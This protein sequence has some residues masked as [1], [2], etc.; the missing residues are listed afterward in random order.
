MNYS[1]SV[2]VGCIGMLAVPT[3]FCES[4]SV[5]TIEELRVAIH[6][7]TA[8]VRAIKADLLKVQIEASAGRLRHLEYQWHVA[9]QEQQ[10]V[11]EEQRDLNQEVNELDESILEP[12]LSPEKRDGLVA[13]RINAQASGTARLATRRASADRRE[14]GI[15]LAYEETRKAHATLLERALSLGLT[16][17]NEGVQSPP[18]GRTND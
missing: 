18:S 6:Q 9:Q 7:L 14:A 10:T 2:I 17:L 5:T 4:T 13:A 1:V 3:A 11:A 15:R 12:H 8:E 16:E